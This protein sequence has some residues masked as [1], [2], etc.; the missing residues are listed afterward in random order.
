MS[1]PAA[2]F[3]LYR[4]TFGEARDRP[5]PALPPGDLRAL[6]RAGGDR[7]AVR[8]ARLGTAPAGDYLHVPEGGI[9][10]FR[11]SDHAQMLLMFAPGG[12]REDYFETL[13]R[14]AE[15]MGDGRAGGVHAPPRHVLGLTAARR[16]ATPTGGPPLSARVPPDRVE[17]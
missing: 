9:H 3:G 5:G 1:S 16:R 6:L 14:A 12:P 13:G 11:G 2:C 7:A 17:A 4:W 8:R 10:G 15:R